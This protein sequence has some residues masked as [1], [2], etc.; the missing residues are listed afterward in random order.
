[1]NTEIREFVST[2]E[3][4]PFKYLRDYEGKEA[5]A[6]I[7]EKNL[8]TGDIYAC[9]VYQAWLDMCRTVPGGGKEDKADLMKAARETAASALRL[10]FSEKPRMSGDIYDRWYDAVRFDIGSQ[11]GLTIGQTQKILNMAFKY[12]YCC[13]DIRNQYTEHFRWCHMPLDS[14]TLKWYTDNC[15]ASKYHGE[16][17]SK[18]DDLYLYHSIQDEIRERFSGESV[19][20]HEFPIWQQEKEAAEKREFIASAKRIVK[21]ENCP[22]SLRSELNQYIEEQEKDKS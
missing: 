19:L 3:K 15:P 7:E 9:A 6:F 18:I 1:M 16:V 4:G 13:E 22:E 5:S 11:S 2:I 14:Y 8:D 17:W 10:Y 20:L 12:L 21:H